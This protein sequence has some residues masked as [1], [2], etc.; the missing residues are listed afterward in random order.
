MSTPP[1]SAIAEARSETDSRASDFAA[2]PA[3][4][5]AIA[6]CL[7]I[8]APHCIRSLAHSREISNARLLPQAALDGSVS[9]PVLSVTS[10]SFKPAPSFHNRFSRGTRTL[11]KRIT[12]L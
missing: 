1:R 2:I 10:A 11:V 3:S 5:W 7:P 6:S 8:F 9:R 12:A 4:I